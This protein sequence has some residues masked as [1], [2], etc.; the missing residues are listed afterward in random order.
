MDGDR[1]V[2]AGELSDYVRRRFRREGEIP[3]DTR[4]DVPG[5]QNLIVERG[6]LRVD[7]GIVRLAGGERLAQAVPQPAP[8]RVPAAPA[9][10]FQPEVDAKNPAIAH[11]PKQD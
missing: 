6:G 7:D 2:T 3:A 4:E 8:I 5:T 10:D 9:R 11:A 1:L